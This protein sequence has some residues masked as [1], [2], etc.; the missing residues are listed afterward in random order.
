[1]GTFVVVA[2]PRIGPSRS[3][4]RRAGAVIEVTLGCDPGAPCRGRATLR[5][6]RRATLNRSSVVAHLAPALGHLS[7][8]AGGRDRI[9]LRLSAFG[10]RL[11]GHRPLGVAVSLL[12][13]LTGGRRQVQRDVVP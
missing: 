2:V 5:V 7:I 4:V 6:A 12:T 9:A 10:H 8:R 3:R 11:L 13:V 1:M